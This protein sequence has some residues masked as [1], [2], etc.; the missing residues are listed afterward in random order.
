VL[1]FLHR[2]RTREQPGALPLLFCG[3]TCLG[4]VEALSSLADEGLLAPPRY[5][6][7]PF[8]ALSRAGR[9]PSLPRLF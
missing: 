9:L 6:P 3:K 8:A 2:A 7:P 4:D 5:L 1:D